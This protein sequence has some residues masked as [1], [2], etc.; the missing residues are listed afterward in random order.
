MYELLRSSADSALRQGS[1]TLAL[2]IL[3]SGAGEFFGG[4]GRGRLPYTL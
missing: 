2:L 1:S 3:G 4:V